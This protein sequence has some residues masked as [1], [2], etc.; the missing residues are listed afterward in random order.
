MKA[1]VQIAVDNDTVSDYV[2]DPD[3]A[4]GKPSTRRSI[5]TLGR[6]RIA[7]PHSLSI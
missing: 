3:V 4:L 1:A 7:K 6:L 5:P 2:S